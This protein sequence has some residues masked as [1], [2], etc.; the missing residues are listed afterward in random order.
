MNHWIRPLCT[1]KEGKA[2]CNTAETK[3]YWFHGQKQNFKQFKQ[4]PL[5]NMHKQYPKFMNKSHHP[6]APTLPA[7]IHKNTLANQQ[8]SK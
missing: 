4:L 8:P 1:D 7:T 3:N 6:R 2:L 5:Q